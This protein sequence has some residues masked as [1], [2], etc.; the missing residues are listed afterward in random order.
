MSN[1]ETQTPQDFEPGVINLFSD[2]LH[3]PKRVT[4]LADGGTEVEFD[5]GICTFPGE[6]TFVYCG[7]RDRWRKDQGFA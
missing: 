7:D 6:I 1:H 3:A 2:G 4:R 5:G